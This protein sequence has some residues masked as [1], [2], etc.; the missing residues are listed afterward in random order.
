MRPT[1]FGRMVALLACVLMGG[2][3]SPGFGRTIGRLMQ[4][5]TSLFTHSGQPQ[6]VRNYV[7]SWKLGSDV[8]SLNA[9]GQSYL[10]TPI[11]RTAQLMVSCHRNTQWSKRWKSKRC[12]ELE[13]CGDNLL[14]EFDRAEHMKPHGPLPSPV[15]LRGL[16]H[17]T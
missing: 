8:W 4:V 17:G 3:R 6:N 15:K 7:R 1:K 10:S 11:A 13:T 9:R 2:T 5:N 12:D 16:L 14:S